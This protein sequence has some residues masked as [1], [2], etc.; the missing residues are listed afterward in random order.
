ML[1]HCAND[2][3]KTMSA[4]VYDGSLQLKTISVPRPKNGEALIKVNCAGVCNT[5]MEIIKGYVPGFNGVMGHEFFGRVVE[6]EDA[7]MEGKRV[8]AEINCACGE[9]D[10]CK[11]GLGRHCPKRTVLGIINSDG[12]FA[13]YVVVPK[14]N[15]FV[16]PDEIADDDAIFIEPL[17]A[18][19]EIVEQVQ[20]VPEAEILILGDGKLGLLISF[21]MKCLEHNVTMVGKHREKLTFAKSLGIKVVMLDEFTN[22][23][24]DIVIEATGNGGALEMAI[25][26]TKPR[27]VVVL[28]STYAG[29]VSFNASKVVVDEISII[30]S[31]CGLFEAA[32]DFLLKYSTQLQLSNLISKKFPLNEGIGAFNYAKGSQTLKCIITT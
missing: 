15:I 17:A 6:C 20:I 19:L 28:K 31:R 29:N 4:L 27:G 22:H 21:V 23:N 1:K 8:T 30:G 25:N 18:A 32:I 26:N 7:G 10:F 5:D 13:E 9:C 12:A 14:Q 3:P 16:I 2:I 24:Y 11:K